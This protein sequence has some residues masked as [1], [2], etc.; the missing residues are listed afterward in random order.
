MPDQGAPGAFFAI[1]ILIEADGWPGEPELQ[2]LADRALGAA[3]AEAQPTLLPGSEVSLV[4][5]DDAAIQRLNAQYRDK[6]KPTNV[7]S[8]PAART[9]SAAFGPLLGDI[10][11]A[12]ETVAREAAEEN[13]PFKHH[14]THLLIHGFLHLLGYDHEQDD[15][16]ALMEGLETAILAGLG[17]AD[18]YRESGRAM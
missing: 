11:L 14:L 2:A 7:L 17:I 12:R 5:A 16:A 8:F 4:F 15:E 3:I 6:D 9:D 1:D 13:L 18:P 10:V